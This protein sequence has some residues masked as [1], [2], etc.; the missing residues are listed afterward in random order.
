MT[1]E[2]KHR[3]KPTQVIL[4]ILVIAGGV[5]V[6]TAFKMTK[7]E[8]KKAPEDNRG[9][10]VD[11]VEASPGTFDVSIEGHGRV[12]PA[13]EVVLQAEV[14]GRVVWQ[15][16]KLVAGGRVQAG[17]K[18]IRLDAREYRLALEQS[19]AQV[20][21]AELEL[22]IEQSRKKVAEREWALLGDEA[23][24]GADDK[25]LALRGPQ[26]RTAKVAVE[27]AKSGVDRA[28]LSIERTVV[29]APFN[30]WVKIENTEVGQLVG[31]GTP[32]ATLIGTDHYHVEITLPLEQV[33]SIAIPGVNA[34]PG[35]GAVAKVVQRAGEVTVEREG[36]VAR[37]LGGLDPAGGMARLVVEIE[38]PLALQ[39]DGG[40]PLFEQA[41]VDVTIAAG[42]L[43]DVYEVPRTALREGNRVFVMSD[44]GLLEPRTVDI[45]WR[46]KDRVL[47]RS[48]IEAGDVVITSRL[49]EAIPGMK[50]RLD[51]PDAGPTTAAAE[52][53]AGQ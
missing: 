52:T 47:L 22:E 26:L 19:K 1:T 37:L 36:R 46:F 49:D 6:F 51:V 32:L 4:P 10:L 50:V 31:P 38:D 16:D 42:S 8:A 43:S 29:K 14:P 20:D 13:R 41:F 33:S 23:A 28:R 24:G 35:E 7:P 53:A 15:H 3:S 9:T 25:S 39:G 17:E 11:V 2:T 30:A 12:R 44:D 45:A 48:G 21:R 18:L 40:L 27:A 5:G 34:K